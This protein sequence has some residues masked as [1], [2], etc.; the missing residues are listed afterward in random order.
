MFYVLAKDEP[1]QLT[2]AIAYSFKPQAIHRAEMLCRVNG[3]SY[4]VVELKTVYTASTL[5]SLMEEDNGR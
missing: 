4:V 1:I 3:E 5:A 2:N